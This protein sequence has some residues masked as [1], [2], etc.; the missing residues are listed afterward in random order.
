MTTTF[1]SIISS[2]GAAEAQRFFLTGLWSIIKG[3]DPMFLLFLSGWPRQTDPSDKTWREEEVLSCLRI[4]YC[5]GNT[6]GWLRMC[7]SVSAITHVFLFEGCTI[8]WLFIFYYWGNVL[9]TLFFRG[10]RNFIRTTCSHFWVHRLSKTELHT[11]ATYICP[12]WIQNHW[13]R[14]NGL[15]FEKLDH[16]TWGIFF[17][18]IG[19]ICIFCF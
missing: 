6:Q 9:F 13:I 12:Q 5:L 14:E 10:K 16:S 8:D 11:W 3:R 7:A 1:A 19:Q 4:T 17:L 18:L 15:A 2:N